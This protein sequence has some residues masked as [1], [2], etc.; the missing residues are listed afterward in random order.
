MRGAR[1]LVWRKADAG[2]T[3]HLRTTHR[4]LARVLVD[5]VYPAM[6]RVHMPSGLVSNL[7]NST[8]AKDAAVSAVL[9]ILNRQGRAQETP[10]EAPYIAQNEKPYVGYPNT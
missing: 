10:S 9:G 3:L 1:D 6:W 5:A 4:V 8:R 2:W 7:A